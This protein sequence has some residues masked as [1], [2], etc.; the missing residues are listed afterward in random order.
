MIWTRSSYDHTGQRRQD[1][2]KTRP[3]T[4]MTSIPAPNRRRYPCKT[5]RIPHGCPPR[6]KGFVRVRRLVGRGHGEARVCHRFEDRA[7]RVFVAA[8]VL[9]RALM[10]EAS[11]AIR[12]REMPNAGARVQINGTRFSALRSELG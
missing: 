3:D 2:A 6:G 4:W 12:P 10:S 1:A 8:F 9:P 5:G 7:E 11:N